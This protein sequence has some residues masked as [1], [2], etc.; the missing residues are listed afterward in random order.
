MN[1]SICC[2]VL[3]FVPAPDGVLH[4]AVDVIEVNRIYGDNCRIV[5][6]QVIFWRWSA[7]DDHYRVAEWRMLRCCGQPEYDRRRGCWVLR[8]WD[9]RDRVRRI[10]TA[11][12][13]R[14]TQTNYDPEIEDREHLP[15]SARVG[16]L[17]VQPAHQSQ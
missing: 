8:W 2:L 17:R 10:V 9:E 4:D 11:W 13:V 14:R 12:D 3:S 5:L 6:E 15:Q 1:P 16:F 7:W